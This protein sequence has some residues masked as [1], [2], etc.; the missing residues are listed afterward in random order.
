MSEIILILVVALVFLGPRKLPELASGLGKMIRE[1]RKATADI[2]SEIELDETIRK[3]LEELREATMLP[4]EEL[5]RRDLERA[6]REKYEREE[7]ERQEQA[8][9]EADQ[10]IGTSAS[11]AQPAADGTMPSYASS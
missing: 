2:K 10:T 7:R 5:K 4:P 3:P 9:K 8:A 1:V 11:E 6:L